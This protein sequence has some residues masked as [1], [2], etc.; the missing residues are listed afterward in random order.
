MNLELKSRFLIL[1]L[2]EG[3]ELNDLVSEWADYVWI[4][5]VQGT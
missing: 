2:I 4:G 1:R 3:D 5:Q